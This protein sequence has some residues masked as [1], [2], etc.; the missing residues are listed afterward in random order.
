MYISDFPPQ[1]IYMYIYIYIYMPMCV[2]V[3][4]RER[5]RERERGGGG[6]GGGGGIRQAGRQVGAG[7]DSLMSEPIICISFLK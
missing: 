2:C 4:E 1:Y 6:W 5:E 3:C 7:V